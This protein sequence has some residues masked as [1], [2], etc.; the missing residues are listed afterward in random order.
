[1]WALARVSGLDRADA[2]ATCQLAWLQLGQQRDLDLDHAPALLI[3]AVH[4][5]SVRLLRRR[6][7]G[8]DV[9]GPVTPPIDLREETSPVWQLSARSRALLVVLTADPPL[10]SREVSFALD[11]PIGSIGP[12]RSRFVDALRAEIAGDDR[13]IAVVAAQQLQDS[14]PPPGLEDLAPRVA[15]PQADEL[16]V[17]TEDSD[18]PDF[19]SSGGDIALASGRLLRFSGRAVAIEVLV[20]ERPAAR[21]VFGRTSKPTELRRVEAWSPTGPVR[22]IDADP[23]RGFELTGLAEGPLA[24][25]LELEHGRSLE[26]EWVRL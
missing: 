15:G 2:L 6:R 14:D 18:H 23:R 25:R 3:R 19:A 16:A 8:I 11:M 10:T 1:M 5:E 9:A 22:S 26:T 12:T 20:R 17:I 7:D 21:D 4:E 13:E 24:I